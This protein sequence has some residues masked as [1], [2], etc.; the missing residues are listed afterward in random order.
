MSNYIH[1]E[2]WDQSSCPFPNFKGKTFEVWEWVSNL[3]V[4]F[5]EHVN[6]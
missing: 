6:T 2:V 5:I 1:N 3:F 4:H